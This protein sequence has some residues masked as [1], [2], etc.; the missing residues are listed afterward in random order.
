MKER[1]QQYELEHKRWS[2]SLSEKYEGIIRTKNDEIEKIRAISDEQ[3]QLIKQY[4]KM[5]EKEKIGA[6]EK[7]SHL[8]N[9]N[10]ILKED[11]IDLKNVMISLLI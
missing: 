4:E 5:I 9:E 8:L 3:N 7:V 6:S 11:I 10:N 2:H 1:A